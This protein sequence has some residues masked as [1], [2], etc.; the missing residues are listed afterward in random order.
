ME[1]AGEKLINLLESALEALHDADSTK[2]EHQNVYARRQI[3][4]ELHVY[5]H[6]Y[7]L[8]INQKA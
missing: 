1:K 7:K 8:E 4:D 2:E 6:L 3:I 5:L